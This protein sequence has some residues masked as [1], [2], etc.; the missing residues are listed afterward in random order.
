MGIIRER[1]KSALT[2]PYSG[3]DPLDLYRSDAPDNPDQP[4]AP[5]PMRFTDWDSPIDDLPARVLRGVRAATSDRF[6]YQDP[7]SLLA[8]IAVN[9][10]IAVTREEYFEPTPD[11]EGAIA[12]LLRTL[13]T[14]ANI[15]VRFLQSLESM[16]ALPP[17]RPRHNPGQFRVQECFIKGPNGTFRD[18][19]P[20]NEIEA[21]MEQL[22]LTVNRGGNVLATW[23]AA[24]AYAQVCIIH[25]FLNG[26]GRVARVLAS[27]ILLRRGWPPIWYVPF[28]NA[29]LYSIFQQLF[30]QG[31]AV[32]GAAFA[33]AFDEIHARSIAKLAEEADAE[34]GADS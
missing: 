33:R 25:P 12:L 13:E 29:R 9:R 7:T 5:W 6:Q 15:D 21:A 1:P 16:L 19:C 34:R 30:A 2:T 26:N 32:R 28:D 18:C 14:A 3:V 27:A 20:P 8:R 10:A 23:L 4:G 17:R 11:R 24:W 22:V 31:P